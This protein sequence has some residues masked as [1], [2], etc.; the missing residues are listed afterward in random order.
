MEN[1]KKV[2]TPKFTD[3]ELDQ[4][5]KE[6]GKEVNKQEKVRIRIPLDPLNKTDLIVPVCINGYVWKI[7]RGKTVTV[8]ENVATILE[9][10]KYI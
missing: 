7:E 10:A 9:E 3:T 5:A 6:A 4:M 2:E 1:I 8:P